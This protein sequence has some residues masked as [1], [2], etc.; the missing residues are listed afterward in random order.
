VLRTIREHCR[1]FGAL[2]ASVEG[3]ALQD[4]LK[5]HCFGCGSLNEQGLQIKSH[6]DG[7]E[8]VC[9]W[10]PKSHHIGHP[11]IVYGGVI[12]SVVD[13]HAVWTAAATACRDEGLPLDDAS[14][15]PFA[16][17]T[18]K[19]TVS[20]LKPARIDRPLELHAQVSDKD[21]RRVNVKCRVLQ[22]GVECASADVVTVR[23]PSLR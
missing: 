23:V 18:G 5:V 4:A 13:C 3:R 1:L 7:D 20:Y 11:G 12:A 6:W 19:L 14:P 15:P 16:F 21:E 10:Q 17:V 8:L 9:R 22:D 2:E